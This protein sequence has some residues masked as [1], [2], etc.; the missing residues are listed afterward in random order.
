M[1]IDPPGMTAADTRAW[2]EKAIFQAVAFGRYPPSCV[3]DQAT[4]AALTTI[5]ESWPRTTQADE[6]AARTALEAS[7]Q[8]LEDLRSIEPN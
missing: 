6:L 2:F 7:L 5:A 8:R 4:K 1:S 3:F